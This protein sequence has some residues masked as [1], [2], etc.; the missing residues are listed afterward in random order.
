MRATGGTRVFLVRAPPGARNPM[1]LAGVHVGTEANPM[2]APDMFAVEQLSKLVQGIRER[3]NSS[4]SDF[5]R[6]AGIHYDRDALRVFHDGAAKS[7]FA[8]DVFLKTYRCVAADGM[9][10]KPDD[11]SCLAWMASH[12]FNKTQPLVLRPVLI[13]AG[14]DTIQR[15]LY[16]AGVLAH[17]VPWLMGPVANSLSVIDFPARHGQPCMVHCLFD[18]S[19]S[20][21]VPGVWG[22][23]IG[24]LDANGEDADTGAGAGAGAGVGAG[25]GA[26]AGAGV[27]VRDGGRYAG[28]DA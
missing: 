8:H 17:Q 5:I 10:D 15:I 1:T 20:L 26:G 9:A 22:N 7:A 21:S 14:F 12:A 28:G 24:T 23:A 13:F 4:S 18:A 16:R 19:L 25:A 3:I 27:V 6:D 2:D 11:R